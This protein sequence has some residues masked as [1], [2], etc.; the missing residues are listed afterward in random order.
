[1]KLIHFETEFCNALRA[2]FN[3]QEYTSETGTM[4]LDNKDITMETDI[5]L[6]VGNNRIYIEDNCIKWYRS[7]YENKVAILV[8]MNRSY[9][10][11]HTTRYTDTH[12]IVFRY[13]DTIMN[14]LLQKDVIKSYAYDSFS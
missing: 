4:Q 10:T 11:I 13:V 1:M 12:G 5:K 3:K 2:I 6:S 14:K 9:P 7:I 8:D